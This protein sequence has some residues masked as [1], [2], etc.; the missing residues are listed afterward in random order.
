MNPCLADTTITL[1]ENAFVF[2]VVQKYLNRISG[3]LL[4]RI[5]IHIEIVP[6]F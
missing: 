2:G 3:P 4:D 1:K 6:V 5:D